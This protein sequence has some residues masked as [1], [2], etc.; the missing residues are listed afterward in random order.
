MSTWNQ[1]QIDGPALTVE[2]HQTD[3]AAALGV[4]FEKFPFQFGTHDSA[5]PLPASCN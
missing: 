3:P 4:L 1:I 2:L 5:L